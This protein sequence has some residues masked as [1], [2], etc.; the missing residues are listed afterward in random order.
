MF[1]KLTTKRDRCRFC[2][3][4]PLAAERTR[5]ETCVRLL[6][7]HAGNDAAALSRGERAYAGAKAHVDAVIAGLTVVLAQEGTP[8]DLADLGT[9]LTRGDQ[10]R[11]ACGMVMRD[12]GDDRCGGLASSSNRVA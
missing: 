2:G 4:V 8:P 9:R 7:R 1:V 11:D 3:A 10:G 6:K 12:D 5:A